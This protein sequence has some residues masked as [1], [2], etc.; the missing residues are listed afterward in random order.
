MAKFLSLLKLNFQALLSAMR[1][2]RKKRSF[3]GM[4]ALALLA[5]LSLYVS[6]VYSAML[7]GQLAAVGAL[8]L[9][10]VLM[11]L[12]AVLLGFFFSLFAAQG[13][14]YGATTT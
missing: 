1:V 3:S 12:V 10:L 13:V 6:G 4:G 5:G 8:P 2:G 14:V 11:S 7:A 9:L